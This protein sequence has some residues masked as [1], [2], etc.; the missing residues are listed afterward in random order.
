MAS[1]IL[2]AFL[3]VK[4]VYCSRRE[5]PLNHIEV[6][7]KCSLFVSDSILKQ[8]LHTQLF[9]EEERSAEIY[10]LLSAKWKLLE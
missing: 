2:I 7:R 1:D 8:T 10:P 5:Q 6:L 4:E 3:R 9:L